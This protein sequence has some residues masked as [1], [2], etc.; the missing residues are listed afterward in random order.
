MHNYMNIQGLMHAILLLAACPEPPWKPRQ[1]F[2][3]DD[4]APIQPEIKSVCSYSQIICRAF[5]DY[6]LL[7]R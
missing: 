3:S 6:H 2:S 5:I 7:P 1:P 4:P